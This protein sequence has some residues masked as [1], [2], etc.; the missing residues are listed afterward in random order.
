MGLRKSLAEG[1]IGCMERGEGGEEG[2]RGRERGE[3]EEG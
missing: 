2:R 3:G 1:D